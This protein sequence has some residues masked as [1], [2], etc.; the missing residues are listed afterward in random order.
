ML[1]IGGVSWLS[2]S[3][4]RGAKTDNYIKGTEPNWPNQ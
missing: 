4:A 2:L 3:Y 1:Y